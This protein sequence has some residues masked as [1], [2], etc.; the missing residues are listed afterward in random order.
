MTQEIFELIQPYLTVWGSGRINLNTADRPV[1][2]S[3][4]GMTEAAVSQLITLRQSGERLN[5]IDDLDP[6][7]T[8]GTNLPNNRTAVLVDELEIE[9]RATAGDG[10]TI[11][12]A[13]GVIR[14]GTGQSSLTNWRVE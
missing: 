6:Y 8:N 3:L 4:T 11:L 5:D 12:R 2:L 9:A 13:F 1:L 7:L 14:R 10:R